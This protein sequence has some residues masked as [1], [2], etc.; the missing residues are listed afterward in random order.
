MGRCRTDLFHRYPL[1][2]GILDIRLIHIFRRFDLLCAFHEYVNSHLLHSQHHGGKR[3]HI[4]FIQRN[5][6]VWDHKSP[7]A[8][9]AQ[10]VRHTDHCR[11]A[12]FLH[13]DQMAFDPCRVNVLASA[14]DHVFLAP[15]DVE[16]SL[17]ID[18][19]QIA[20]IEPSPLVRHLSEVLPIPEVTGG[21]PSLLQANSPIEPIGKGRRS[22][23]TILT[24]IPGM[25]RPTVSAWRDG[26]S[27]RLLA[28][29][30]PPNSVIPKPI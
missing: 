27:S 15:H 2:P 21:I 19:G 10:F 3:Q 22:S 29:I 25:G 9:P 18:H 28:A 23:S 30:P 16:I 12:H 14:D 24:S 8:F 4:L 1:R 13:G 26:A 17:L 7:H 5:P 6:I 20:R 11:F